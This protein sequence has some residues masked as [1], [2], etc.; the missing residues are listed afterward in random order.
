MGR[1]WIRMTI[2][3]EDTVENLILGMDPNALLGY[4]PVLGL[5]HPIMSTVG[6]T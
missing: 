2:R 5:Q 1:R 4:A 3:W 6:V